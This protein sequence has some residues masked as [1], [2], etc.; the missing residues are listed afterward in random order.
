MNINTITDPVQTTRPQRRSRIQRV[1]SKLYCLSVVCLFI[2]LCA[3]ALVPAPVI[4]QPSLLTATLPS[5]QVNTAYYAK[6]AASGGTPPYTW[7]IIS[8]SLPPWLNLVPDTGAI[9]GTPGTQGTVQFEADQ[10]TQ[11]RFSSWSLPAGEQVAGGNLNQG[12]YAPAVYTANYDI[13][14]RLTFTSPLGEQKES[15]WYKSGTRADWDLSVVQVP[16]SGI[17]GFFRGTLNAINGRGSVVMD[18]PQNITV[19]WEPDYTLPLILIPAA[20]L[21]AIICIC[22]LY[23]LSRGPVNQPLPYYP[24]A[25]SQPPTFQPV[26][27]QYYPAPPPAYYRPPPVNFIP[28]PAQPVY[29][30]I[31]VPVLRPES[32]ATR[33]AEA[34][35]RDSHSTSMQKIV[36][37][38]GKLLDNYAQDVVAS[39]QNPPPGLTKADE[40]TRITVAGPRQ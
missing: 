15:A 2:S 27:P 38:L 25:Q 28:F 13:Y 16:M 14:Y 20:L 36:Q 9:A 12:I 7:S 6:L 10:G 35:K 5:A 29:T 23:A 11:Y 40:G 39:R 32:F 30:P 33:I 37:E 8:G 19:A 3:L 31:I 4:A 24:A 1:L 34:P 18:K 21:L 17:M 22:G 26:M